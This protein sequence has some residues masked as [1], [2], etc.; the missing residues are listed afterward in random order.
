MLEPKALRLGAANSSKLRRAFERA[1][2]THKGVE[3]TALYTVGAVS[4]DYQDCK[5]LKKR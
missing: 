3:S 5:V 2:E 4:G 1:Y